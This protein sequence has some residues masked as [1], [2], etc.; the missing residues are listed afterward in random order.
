MK[1]R[2]HIDTAESH[3][4]TCNHGTGLDNAPDRRTSQRIFG[5]HGEE[6]VAQRYRD[7]GFEIIGRNWTC[8]EG[9]LDVIARTENLVVFCEVKTR[10]SSRFADPA[11]SVDFHK[12]KRIRR[13]ALRW[14]AS[15]QDWIPH[16]R[17]DV[18]IVLGNQIRWIENAF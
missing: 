10:S 6:L 8:R 2:N 1:E 9:E 13:A 15:N 18:A 12:Q 16:M 17:F 4:N 5:D 7:A 11:E 3:A 14:L